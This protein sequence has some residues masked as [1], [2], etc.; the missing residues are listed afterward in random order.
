MNLKVFRNQFFLFVVI[1][2]F[3]SCGDCSIPIVSKSPLITQ[4]TPNS[5]LN[6]NIGTDGI[7]FAGDKPR[8]STC[9]GA[10]WLND[11]AHLITVNMHACTVQLYA[12]NEFEKKLSLIRNYTNDD[13]FKLA[14]PESVDVA[15]NGNF[16]V[17]PNMSSGK[18][19]FHSLSNDKLLNPEA[20]MVISSSKVHG[21]KLSP[22]ERYLVSAS[23]V[24]GLNVYDITQESPRLVQNL[25]QPYFPLKAKTIDFSPDGHF[26][27]IGYCGVYSVLGK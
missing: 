27:A 9:S 24:E 25:G 11:S 13:G 3:F 4:Y 19:L 26:V 23:F 2:L 10:C 7:R 16:I 12:F 18:I 20:N 14:R 22:D 17:I 5:V 21:V 15:N 1:S 8:Y 6:A